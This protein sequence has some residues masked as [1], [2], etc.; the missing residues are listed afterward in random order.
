MFP[1]LKIDDIIAT[2]AKIILIEQ[3]ELHICAQ[4]MQITRKTCLDVKKK[5]FFLKKS[6]I[7][8]PFGFFLKKLIIGI[9]TE[10]AKEE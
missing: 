5:T 8:S 10:K 4:H 9:L 2:C 6:M 1:K 3:N 7:G